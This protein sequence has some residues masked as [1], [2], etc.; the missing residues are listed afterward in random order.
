MA[1]R[2]TEPVPPDE[3]NPAR[4]TWRRLRALSRFSIQSKVMLM[5]LVAS[6]ASLGVIGTVEYV[7]ARNALLPA[8]SERMTQMRAA[9]KRAI[10]TLFSDLSDSLVVY[11]HGTTALDAVREFTAGF[12]QLAN[13]P[14]DPGQQRALVD[15]Y[16]KKLIEPIERDTG[17]KLALDAVLP[18]NNAQKYLQ[19]HYTVAANRSS[20][21]TGSTPD[22]A[23]DGS[24][25]SAANARFNDYFREIATRFEYRD[26]LLLDTRGNV[27][28]SVKKSASLGTNVRTGPYRQSNLRDAYEKAMAANSVDFVWITDFAPYQAQLGQPIA[29]LTAPIGPP[30]NAAGV[31]ALPL[32]IAKVNRIMTA[33][34]QWKAAGMGDTAETYLA[35]PDHLMRSDSRLFLEDPQRY[36]RDAVAAGTR[37]AAVD[38]AIRWG[39]TTLV[40]PVATAAVR[41]A[42]RGE[43]G[44]LTDTS[45]L[46][47]R[48]LAA[49]APLS[50]PNSDLHWSIVATRE[51]AEANARVMSLTQTLVI[52][53]TAMVFV[54]CVAALL[55]AQ[56]FVRPIRRLQAGAQE[57]GAGNYDVAIPVTSHD[58]I[59]E[60]TAAFNEM[61]R[62][63]QIKEELLGEQRKENDRLLGSL[64]PEPVARRYREGEHTIAQ[65]HQDVTVI[66]ADLVG[67]DEI[68]GRLS[69]RELVGIVDELIREL[70]SAAESLGIEPIRTLHNGYL[71]SCGL[72]FPRLDSVHRTVEFAVEMKDIIARFNARTGYHLA[73][74]AGINTGNVISGLVGRSSIV[75]D[76]W[77]AAVNL[78]HQTRSSTTQTGIYV[79]SKVYEVMHDIRQFTPAGTITVGGVE[80]QIWKLSE[81]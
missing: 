19:A 71:A 55:V 7:A 16:T 34:K 79:T 5:L 59:G 21:Q 24:A 26:A 2:S 73:L 42:D 14:V 62:N 4:T 70:D 23:G 39:G 44:T 61:S 63:L 11:S 30:G 20:N 77:G 36:K 56:I 27:V 35:G 3:Q 58:E 33:D 22:D 6:L 46:G 78:A 74:R 45:Y 40:Q 10:E 31:L 18:S 65:E 67:L 28:Y 53:T 72:N 48:E 57:I 64:M 17:K 69:G 50:V 32:P 8:A 41:A 51:T 15:F 75:Y 9:Q 13:A 60:L 38:T 80:Q 37:P 76:M 54:I 68:S 49:Y 66:F 1:G 43:S 81:G 25:W 12:D 52:T 47:R 29:W